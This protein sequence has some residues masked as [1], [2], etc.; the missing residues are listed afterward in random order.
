MVSPSIGMD[1]EPLPW[2]VWKILLWIAFLMLLSGIVGGICSVLT[3]YLPPD[4]GGGNAHMHLTLSTAVAYLVYPT[5]GL[6]FIAWRL[7]GAGLTVRDVWGPLRARSADLADAALLGALLATAHWFLLGSDRLEGA[8]SGWRWGL[9]GIQFLGLGMVAP[10]LEEL[11]FR[12]MLYRV[13]RGRFRVVP[14][15][16]AATGVFMASHPE[17]VGQPIRFVLVAVAGVAMA[18]IYERTRSLSTSTVLH[19]TVNV[20]AVAFQLAGP[21]H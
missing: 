1:M 17:L 12:G 8:E 20:A 14:A 21:W 9:I 13:L 11:V 7:A 10:V 4:I 3:L 5:L 19:I 2:S 6:G 18:L 16:T 15:V